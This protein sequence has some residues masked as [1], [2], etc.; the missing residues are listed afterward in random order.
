MILTDLPYGTTRNRWDTPIDLPLLWKEFNRVIKSNGA[1]C[2]NAQQPFASTLVNS[3]IKNYRYSWIWVKPQGT[4]HLN[5]KKMPLKAYE[6]ICVFYKK[7]PVYNPQWREGKPYKVISGGGSSNYGEQHS[8]ETVSDGRRYPLDV[9]YFNK[10]KEKLHPTQKP[11]ELC[12]Y[13]I[14]TYTNEGDVVLDCCMGS[15]STGVAALE[16]NRNFIGYELDEKY[17]EIA[18]ERI[19]RICKS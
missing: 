10:D 19:K 17:F 7:L 2:L 16:E 12:K 3:N 1:I 14:K 6:E 4:G 13:L 18:E 5:A 15:G 8:V 11:I 9:L